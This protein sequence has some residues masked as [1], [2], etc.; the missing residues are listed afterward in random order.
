[1]RNCVRSVTFC[2][3]AGSWVSSDSRALY[4]DVDS[5]TFPRILKELLGKK[6]FALKKEL[7]GQP[8]V[9]P[10]WAHCLSYEYELRRE[11]YKRCREQSVGFNAAWWGTCADT[12]HGMLHWLQLVC[13]ANSVSQAPQK[14]IASLVQKEVATQLKR[15]GADRSRTPRFNW[16]GGEGRPQLPAPQQLALPGPA[17]SSSASSSA[18]KVNGKGNAKKQKKGKRPPAG[19]VWTMRDLLRGGPEVQNMLHGA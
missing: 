8:L 18:P 1:M 3:T 14:S 9:A 15:S 6:N 13:S 10:P 19:K 16:G 11:A 7:E 4:S 2:Q 5:N 17:A 12:E